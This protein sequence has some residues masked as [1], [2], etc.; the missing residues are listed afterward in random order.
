MKSAYSRTHLGLRGCGFL[1]G[2][3]P[4]SVALAQV[5]TSV[6]VGN[7]VDASTRTPV[8]DVVVTAT[9]PSLQG[10]QVVVTDGTGLYRVPQLPSGVYTLRF[11]KESYRPFSRSGIEVA[12]DQTLRLNVELLPETA[13]SETVTVIGTPPIIDIGSSATGTTVNQEFMRNLPVARPG[14]LG[15]ANRS[16]DSLATTAPQANADF[17]GVGINGATSPENLFL[18]DGIS[19]NNPGF[20]TLGTPLTAEFMGEIDIVTGGY[21]PEYGRNSGGVISAVT[22]SGGNEFHGSVFGTFTPGSLTGTPGTVGGATSTV[23]GKREVGN[24]GDIGATLGGYLIKDRLWFFAGFQWSA[25]RYIYSRSFN[26]LINGQTEAIPNSTQRWNGDERSIN[27]IGKLTYLISSDHRVSLTVTG[28][29]TTGGGEGGVPLRNQSSN[30]V[31]FGPTLLT[32]GTSN[33]RYAGSRSKFDSLDLAGELNSAFLDKRLLLDVRLGAHFQRDSSLPRDGSGLDNIDKPSVLAGVPLVRSPGGVP[34]PIYE[35]DASVPSSVRTKCSELGASCNVVRF[36]TGGPGKI[37]TLDF[38]SYQARAVLTYLVNAAG[39]HVLKAGFDGQINKYNHDESFSGGAL[40]VDGQDYGA[41]AGTVVDFV[42]FG[43]LSGTD[44]I[45]DTPRVQ[46]NTKSTILGGFIQDSWSVLD[47][48]TLNLGLRF[49]TLAMQGQDGKTRISLGDQLSP[50]VGLVWDPTQ[51]GRSKLFVNYGRYYEYIPLDIADRSLSSS[52][53]SITGL[54]QCDPLQVGRQG[55]DAN[56]RTDGQYFINGVTQAPNRKWAAGAGPYASYVDPHLKS[57]ANDEI[58][59]G[60]EYEVLPSARAGLTYTYR[61]LIRTVEDMSNNDGQTLFIGNPG[62]GIGDTFPRA[63]RKYQAVTVLFTK[64][65]SDL[66]LAQASY[67]WAQLRGNYEGLFSTQGFDSLGVPQLDPNINGTFDLRTLMPNQTGPLPSDI[68]HNIKLY[69][70]KEFAIAPVLSTTLGG[71]F[72]ANSGPPINALG[73]HPIYGAGQAYILERGGA[74]R[75]PWVTS[76]DA[77]I[78]LNYRLGKDSVFTAAVEG[79]NLFNSQR[80]VTVDENYTAGTVTPILGAKQGSVPTEFGG[81][82]ANASAASCASGNGSLPQ[83][84][85]NPNLPTGGAIRVGL[86]NPNGAVSSQVVSLTW[87]TPTNYQPV[88]QFRFSLRVTF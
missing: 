31:P 7:V 73:A 22:K 38:D 17:Y 64:S 19:V 59:A 34:T 55:C 2:L 20:G 70:A 5:S 29:P 71:S 51:Q 42:H 86:P 27:Y 46:T 50:R 33:S 13:G 78:G 72:T 39:H 23:Q 3:L 85:V 57:P 32:L 62:E 44:V 79:F 15:G 77:K 30:R 49:D 61:N 87:G 75:L 88:R 76:F 26:R 10:E 69:L 4:A 60:A 12:A 63:E 81:I 58:V 74:G 41:P 52:Q 66:W 8:A 6:L 67:T 43:H 35:L 56:T 82:C 21:M 1:L 16:F 40:Y 54:H 68:T 28:T 36:F 9:S 80:P 14:G 47:K 37:E 83:P 25:Q 11:E 48:V 18:I 53:A 45:V 84:R 24:F 65:F